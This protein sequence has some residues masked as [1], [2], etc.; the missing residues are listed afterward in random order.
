MYVETA[1]HLLPFGCVSSEE[2]QWF[3]VHTRAR[4]EKSVAAQLEQ[5]GLTAFAPVFTQ[6]RQWSDR[7]KIVELPMFSCYAFVRIAPLAQTRQA[8]VRTPGVLGFVGISGLGIPIPEKEI[9]DVRN[10]AKS[11]S[12]LAPYPYVSVGQRVRVVGGSLNGLEGILLEQNSDD[13]IVVSIELIQ[14]S[15]AVRLDGY[16]IE[17]I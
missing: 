14:R 8:V 4:H 5:K 12:R 10:L 16:N 17:V 1:Y 2:P 13:T 7:R 3:A 11:S 15:V 6:V 9:D